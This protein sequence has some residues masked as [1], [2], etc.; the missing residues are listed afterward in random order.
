MAFGID[1]RVLALVGLVIGWLLVNQQEQNGNGNGGG[2]GSGNGGTNQPPTASFVHT[3]SETTI[4]LDGSGSSDPEGDSLL[5]DWTVTGTCDGQS[6]TKTATGVTA[7][8][9]VPCATTYEVSLTVT[10]AAGNTD[11][12][13]KSVTVEDGGGN[14]NGNGGGGSDYSITAD[15]HLEDATALFGDDFA[16]NYEAE[17][18]GASGDGSTN[19]LTHDFTLRREDSPDGGVFRSTTVE[20]TAGSKRAVK[21]F[22]TGSMVGGEMTGSITLNLPPGTYEP[23]WRSDLEHVIATF[24]MS[25]D[26]ATGTIDVEGAE[27]HI[28]DSWTWTLS[29]TCDGQ[30]IQQ[31]TQTGQTAT[32]Q[33]SCDVADLAVTLAVD[34]EAMDSTQGS[35]TTTKPVTWDTTQTQ[36]PTTSRAAS[37]RR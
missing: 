19:T 12:E 32:F 27:A 18:T 24:T 7:I 25:V 28:I 34:G 11:T 16:S 31:R 14:G 29:G 9:D 36:S 15:T 26:P 6:V 17:G 4:E 22:D 20:L 30:L 37:L 35:D 21:T 23:T 1:N 10:D 3:T 2:N 33:V 13:T 5:Y 8:V